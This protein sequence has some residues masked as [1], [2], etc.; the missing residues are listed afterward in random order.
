MMQITQQAAI[1]VILC[2]P[3]PRLRVSPAQNY[4]VTSDPFRNMHYKPFGSEPGPIIAPSDS[5]LLQRTQSRSVW[6]DADVSYSLSQFRVAGGTGSFSRL[7][8]AENITDLPNTWLG[9]AYTRVP[10]TGYRSVYGYGDDNRV[11]LSIDFLGR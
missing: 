10:Q 2:G 8:I 5:Y 11:Q 7:D 4:S 1:A 6:A 3:S 9:N